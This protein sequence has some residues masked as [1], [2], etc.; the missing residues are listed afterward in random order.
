MT[1]LIATSATEFFKMLERDGNNTGR[2]YV[3]MCIIKC[4]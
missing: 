1:H 4:I 2:E 3:C